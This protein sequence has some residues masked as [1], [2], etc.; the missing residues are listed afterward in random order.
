MTRK[1]RTHHAVEVAHPRSKQ[2]AAQSFGFM[3]CID[4]PAL[5]GRLYL[6]FPSGGSLA[7]A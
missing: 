7:G 1:A 5:R 2:P 4:L 3:F 6:P